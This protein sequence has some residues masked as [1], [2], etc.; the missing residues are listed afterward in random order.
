MNQEN[1][2]PESNMKPLKDIK[3]LATRIKQYI[4]QLERSISERRN[5]V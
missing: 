3:N 1:A 5:S 2:Q 4:E